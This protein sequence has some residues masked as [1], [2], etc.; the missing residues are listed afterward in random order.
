L[1]TIVRNSYRI[2]ESYINTAM[3]V[4]PHNRSIDFAVLQ[5]VQDSRCASGILSSFENKS[6]MQLAYPILD[7][8]G[9]HSNGINHAQ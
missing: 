7:H 4:I 5:S 9:D 2:F 6:G 8:A 1:K 3:P